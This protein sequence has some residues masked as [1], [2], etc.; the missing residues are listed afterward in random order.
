MG[1]SII[2]AR[3]PYTLE[4]QVVNISDRIA[5]INHD[6]D[7]AIRAGIIKSDD[8]PKDCVDILGDPWK[9]NS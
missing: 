4:G 6:I 2:K 7:D 5:Y 8:L 3:T 1:Y 9:A